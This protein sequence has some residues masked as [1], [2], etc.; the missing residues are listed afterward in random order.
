MDYK[1]VNNLT[2]WAVF[3]VSAYT[4]LATIEPTAS[5]WDCGEY[6]ATSY[7]LQV[8]H[9]PGAPLF[10]MIG[11]FFSL[12]AGGD[13]TRAAKM[14]NI[15]S[16]LSSAF[17][18]LFLFWSI[19]HIA[20]KLVEHKLKGPDDKAGS[21]KPVISDARIMAIMGCGIVGA[22]AYNFSDSFWFSAV[23]GEVYGMSQ[24]CTAAAF[25]LILKW[26]SVADQPHSERWI[27]L[28]AYVIGLS[29][30]VHLLNLLTIPAIVFIFYFKKYKVTPK[31]FII[32]LILSVAL[33][34]G[35]LNGVIPGIIN[36]AANFEIFFVNAASLPYNSGTI[37]YFL[38]MLGIVTTG[39]MY[40][41]NEKDKYFNSFLGLSALFFVISLL[42]SQNGPTGA[43]RFVVGGTLLGLIY[44]F[45]KK[46][47]IWNTVI[48]CFSM[49]VIG[50]SSFMML[51]IRS[52]APTPMNENAPK[53][54][55]G[56]LSYLG[57]EQYG[58][59]PLL[60]GQYYNAPLD[61]QKPYMD[62][63]PVYMRASDP[64]AGPKNDSKLKLPVESPNSPSKNVGGGRDRYI[65]SDDRTSTI[66]NYDPAFCTYFPRMWNSESNH[67]SAYRN[68]GGVK[69][70]KT[71]DA[72][73]HERPVRPTFG[74]NL[75]YFFSYQVGWM[76]WRYFFWNFAGRQNDI[77]GHGN[78][79]DG[80]WI[81][82]FQ[83]F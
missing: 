75:T 82:G 67:I 6:I 79:T 15:M 57:R 42:S 36:L 3:A 4:F 39:L 62:G 33:L 5:F 47:I 17:A 64:A 55:I 74:E 61:P 30:G 54:A 53:D 20:R 81:T 23:E 49:L 8:G 37:I 26:E 56:L 12:F 65:I 77:Q 19:T 72:E 24:L 28:I 46:V 50:Y 43:F 60:Y 11:R 52:N 69:H 13:V 25:W 51:V 2:G 9:P 27:V 1:K 48:L 41:H 80:N 76:F 29:I 31:G 35:I 22:L 10:Q 73:G 78:Q 34:G 58:D 14:V 83:S 70:D 18:V 16:A 21:A 40:T 66:P 44:Y 45:R 68:W 63:N 38:L 7:K 71:T 59:W 32:S